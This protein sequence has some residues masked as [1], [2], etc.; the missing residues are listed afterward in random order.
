MLEDDFEWALGLFII[1]GLSDAVDGYLAK[2]FNW[3]SRLGEILDPLADKLLMISCYLVLGWLNHLPMLLV[4]VVIA[5]DI[6][7]VLGAVTYNF[8][9]QKITIA[10]TYISK[11]NT[12]AQIL[13][14]CIVLFSLV[15]FELPEKGLNAM[16]IIVFITT[17][18]SG[19]NY[20]VIWSK[21]SIKNRQI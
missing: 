12:T 21:R 10:P 6:I 3:V 13:L 2:R 5:R 4:M 14:I 9:I 17:M 7:I 15:V 16:F 19:I 1:A 8:N 20:V 11:I 18:A